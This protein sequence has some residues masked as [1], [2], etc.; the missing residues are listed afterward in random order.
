MKERPAY[1]TY[2][3]PYEE[4]PYFSA[5]D[6]AYST[7]P[8]RFETLVSYSPD[9]KGLGQALEHRTQYPIDRNLLYQTLIKQYNDI[10]QETQGLDILL[11]QDCFTVTSAH[12]PVLLGGPLYT[13]YKIAASIHLS[14]RLSKE[15]DKIIRP[16]F[17]MGTE[18]HDFEEI[19]HVHLFNEVIQWNTSQP[20][21][22]VGR[23]HTEELRSLLS[24]VIHPILGS[25]SYAETL[26]ELIGNSFI[27]GRAYGRSYQAFLL[28][29][30]ADTELIVLDMDDPAFKHH[31]K[32]IL[33]EEILHAP[34]K[35][36]TLRR[37]KV[38]QEKWGGKAQIFPR[39]IN[40][41]YQEN[42]LR[43]RIEK[44]EEG[45][46]VLDTSIVFNQ[47]RLLETLEQHPDR[48]SPNVVLRP[49]YQE[50]ILPNIAFIGGPSEVAYWME[51]RDVFKHFDVHYP[52]LL[53]RPS[54]IWINTREAEVLDRYG[55]ASQEHLLQGIKRW[56][57]SFIA[58]SN[59]RPIPYDSAEKHLQKVYA[60]L[61]K[62]ASEEELHLEAYIEAAEKKG[63]QLLQ[64]V[65]AKL[66]KAIKQKH[67]ISI[68]KLH[69]VHSQ[70]FPGGK[71]QERVNNFIPNYLRLGPSFFNILIDQLDPL[72]PGLKV[73]KVLP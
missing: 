59:T 62:Y 24:E 64:Q 29:I 43:K 8:E 20:I 44:S 65:N 56:E 22:P 31:F 66:N 10:G 42:G 4:V 34:T 17:V 1:T 3:L 33:Q 41:F 26:K 19:N 73:F 67:G 52:V 45:W 12:Q 25:S 6:K 53:R 15:S 30:F 37:Q 39:P 58:Q 36:L 63:L 18:D 49:I 2:S 40:L 46:Q 72:S 61:L 9:L 21:G 5:R 50:Y 69:K 70:L 11:S 68:R 16:L 13:I 27:P 51:I 71:L 28:K 60:A 57:A 32:S 35:E 54:A 38:L 55:L 47:T 7:H 48:F 14:R 23:L